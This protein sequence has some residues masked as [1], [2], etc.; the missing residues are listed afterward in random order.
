MPVCPGIHNS[1]ME[2]ARN[3]SSVQKLLSVLG[4]RSA[5]RRANPFVHR[6]ELAEG[7]VIFTAKA[8]RLVRVTN[9]VEGGPALPPL[10]VD[11]MRLRVDLTG[12]WSRDR[13]SWVSIETINADA[14]KEAVPPAVVQSAQ[15]LLREVVVPRRRLSIEAEFVAVGLNRRRLDDEIAQ[16]EMEIARRKTKLKQLKSR[17]GSEVTFFDEQVAALKSE[18]EGLLE[19]E[20]ALA[21]MPGF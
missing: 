16:V 14:R 7:T 5:P 19:P 17:R 20:E 4:E 11:G 12:R 21:P 6:V 2:R 9:L 10:V 8:Q 13:F 3:P 18:L 1:I 15:L